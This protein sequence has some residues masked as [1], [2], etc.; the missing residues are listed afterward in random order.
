MRYKIA[1]LILCISCAAPESP[2]TPIKARI[3]ASD[4]DGS[5]DIQDV[6]FETLASI[7][8]LEGTLASVK[9]GAVLT[10]NQDLEEIIVSE[11]PEDIYSNPGYGF[12]VNYKLIDQVIHPKD[13]NSMAALA[14]YY[15]FEKT[16]K[17][18]EDFNGLTLEQFGYTT[19]HNNPT[20]EIK[21]EVISSKTQM[22]S[23]ASFIIGVRHLNFHKKTSR[24][25]IP[26]KMNQG[27]MAHEFFHSLF[28][29]MVAEKDSRFYVRD[30][31]GSAV[32]RAINEGLADFF[33][34]LATQN[35]DFI[36]ASLPELKDSRTPPVPWTESNFT[37]QCFN[38]GYC[39]GSVLNSALYESGQSIGMEVVARYVLS[40]LPKLGDQWRALE[41]SDSSVTEYEVYEFVNLVLNEATDAHRQTLCESMI[42]WFDS[43]KGELNCN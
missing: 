7:A 23:N 31:K 18:W 13:F 22:K 41:T 20:V 16:F 38:Y 29:V 27:I 28:D 35:S 8:P 11:H 43:S 15:N 34:I 40:A 17:F 37:L 3:L 9:S 21:D 42:R 6:E 12:D 4:A 10:L 14:I 32:L 19:I 5:Y 30:Y 33:A 24:T 1:M 36:S 2:N 26:I 25:S 39:L